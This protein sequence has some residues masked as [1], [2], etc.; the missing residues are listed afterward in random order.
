MLHAKVNKWLE[1][2]QHQAWWKYL[3][4]TLVS[5]YFSSV[6]ADWTWSLS[7]LSNSL[8]SKFSLYLHTLLILSYFCC[9]S[10]NKDMET[11]KNQFMVSVDGIRE[12]SV[13]DSDS[14]FFLLGGDPLIRVRVQRPHHCLVLPVFM[15]D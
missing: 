9:T 11:W 5:I 14:E 1:S 10:S 15:S 8:W 7:P 4:I 2:L 3:I 12:R 6:C 13:P